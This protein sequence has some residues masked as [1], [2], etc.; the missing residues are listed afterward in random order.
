MLLESTA[1]AQPAATK[2]VIEMKLRHIFLL[3]MVLCLSVAS[4]G[5]VKKGPARD[6]KT[7]RFMKKVEAPKKALPPRD[8]KTGRFIKKADADKMKKA[9]PARDPKTGRFIKKK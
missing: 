4:F 5:Q 8:P 7:G 6:P 3:V 9:G 2:K 1:A